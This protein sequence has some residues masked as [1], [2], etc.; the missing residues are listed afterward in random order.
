MG[1]PDESDSSGYCV[2]INVYDLVWNR[3]RFL[4]P[5]RRS[6]CCQIPINSYMHWAGLGVYHTGVQI[7]GDGS[8]VFKSLFFAWW[9]IFFRMGIWRTSIRLFWGI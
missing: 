8:Y 7:L 9:L 2:Y 3:M 4:A 1:N 5:F 6:N